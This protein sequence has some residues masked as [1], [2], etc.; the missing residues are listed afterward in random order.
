MCRNIRVLFHFEP[1]TTDDE[2]RAAALQFVRKVSGQTRPTSDNRLAFEAAVEAVTQATTALVRAGLNSR[3]APR[4]RERE[5]ER[6]RS[7]GRA[8]ELRATHSL[9][10]VFFLPFAAAAPPAVALFERIAPELRLLLP[11]GAEV[12][13]VG[14]TTIPGSWTKGDLDICVRVP[15]DQFAKA[16]EV[17][18][19]RFMRNLGSTRS[20]T[21]SAFE[22]NAAT[23]P[24]G[25]Q[26]VVHG[27]DND[28]FH[29]L[30]EQLRSDPALVEQLNNIR[31]R[32]DGQAMDAYRAEKSAFYEALLGR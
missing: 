29:R 15:A 12:D 4:T 26:L 30:A 17:L 22:D 31:N 2:I 14:A 9:Q 24:L 21:F 11:T 20:A 8:R 23:P 27:S 6:A 13:H 3:G 7:R 5:R 10:R 32:H 25:V 1:P 19:A 18:A 28:V 16:D